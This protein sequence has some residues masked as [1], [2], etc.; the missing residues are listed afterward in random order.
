MLEPPA[1]PNNVE[2]M[3]ARARLMLQP[4]ERNYD[5]EQRLAATLASLPRPAAAGTQ[6][7]ARPSYYQLLQR[8]IKDAEAQKQRD[9]AEAARRA[10]F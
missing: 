3:A 4:F 2:L 9:A 1:D 5:E 6:A 8:D 7:G 10:G